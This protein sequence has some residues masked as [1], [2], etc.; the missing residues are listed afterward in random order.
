MLF[1]DAALVESAVAQHGSIPK[2]PAACSSG[3]DNHYLL[4]QLGKLIIINGSTCYSIS[5]DLGL[6]SS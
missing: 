5:S 1:L 3:K 2:Q 4:L 6:K